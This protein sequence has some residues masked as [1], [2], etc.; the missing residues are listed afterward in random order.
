MGKIA[1]GLEALR[2][3]EDEKRQLKGNQAEMLRKVGDAKKE[4]SNPKNK[5]TTREKSLET[6]ALTTRVNLRSCESRPSTAIW[7]S[8]ILKIELPIWAT[9]VLRLNLLRRSS[10]AFGPSTLSGRAKF[11]C[12]TEPLIV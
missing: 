4:N 9:S 8:T 2:K 6:F 5:L 7:S 10:P 12:S 11:N 1:Q 3:L